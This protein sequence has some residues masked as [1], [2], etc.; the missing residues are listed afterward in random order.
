MHINNSH[1]TQTANVFTRIISNVEE[2]F[3]H[4]KESMTSIKNSCKTFLF[5]SDQ[6]KQQNIEKICGEFIYRIKN[7]EIK[8]FDEH[9]MNQY[10]NIST[11]FT[12]HTFS[13]DEK[14][15]FALIKN[16]IINNTDKSLSLF[17]GHANGSINLM[18]ATLQQAIN[19]ADKCG[20]SNILTEQIYSF[21][22]VNF[23]IDKYD[24][25]VI[26]NNISKNYGKEIAELENM[27]GERI[28]KAL[29]KAKLLNENLKSSTF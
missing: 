22:A 13:K 12:H 19:K 23:L 15:L 1:Q 16:E 6:R 20:G 14:G 28:E 3:A 25:E 21:M 24:A 18:L 17:K 11:R 5:G 8:S 10:L 27:A 2:Q 4:L 26:L 29:I 7:E 9:K